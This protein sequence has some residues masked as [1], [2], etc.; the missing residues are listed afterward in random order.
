MT[1]TATRPADTGT[2]EPRCEEC[3]GRTVRVCSACLK[4]LHSAETTPIMYCW[5]VH[6][7]HCEAR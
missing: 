3:G 2:D 5:W 1:T 4:P 6:R 7:D